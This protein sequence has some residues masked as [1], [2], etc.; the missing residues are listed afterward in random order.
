MVSSQQ[1]SYGQQVQPST[2][3]RTQYRRRMRLPWSTL[4]N[5]A[6]PESFAFLSASLKFAGRIMPSDLNQWRSAQAN[7]CCTSKK[8]G[9][10]TIRMNTQEIISTLK[11]ERDRL[12]QAIAAL[13]NHT[14]RRR[15]RPKNRHQTAAA[16]R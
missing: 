9:I 15:G 3:L 14:G 10:K 8:K 1:T 13:T 7:R 6:P 16:R 5:L 4:L 2:S 12:N 11:Q